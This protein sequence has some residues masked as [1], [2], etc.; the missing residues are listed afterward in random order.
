MQVQAVAG[1]DLAHVDGLNQQGVYRVVYMNG[2]VEGVDRPGVNGGDIL[3][4][5]T[6]LTAT[7]PATDVWLV[8]EILEPWDTAGW[9]RVLVV[10]QQAVQYQ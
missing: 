5:P 8:K 7:P 1:Q 3:L 4:I 10:L 2:R 9:S 6:G